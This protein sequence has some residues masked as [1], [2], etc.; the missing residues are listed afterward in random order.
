MTPC[1]WL[2][3]GYSEHNSSWCSVVL[4]GLSVC[5]RLLVKFSKCN[6]TNGNEEGQWRIP[7]DTKFVYLFTVFRCETWSLTMKMEQRREDKIN[8]VEYLPCKMIYAKGNTY[9]TFGD[10]RGIFVQNR[11]SCSLS[12]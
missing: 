1:R 9:V 4:G 5:Q 7:W 11:G 12:I 6:Y 2:M 8:Y 10:F 3:V